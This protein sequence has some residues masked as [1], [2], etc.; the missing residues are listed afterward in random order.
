MLIGRSNRALVGV[1]LGPGTL[2]AEHPDGGQDSCQGDSGK[3]LLSF[4]SHPRTQAVQLGIVSAGIG[5]GREGIPGIYTRVSHYRQWI[6]A[7]LQGERL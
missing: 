7:V 6:D 2:C 5:C 3:G 1:E 4:P